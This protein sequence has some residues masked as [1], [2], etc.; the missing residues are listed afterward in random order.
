[1]IPK[2]RLAVYGLIILLFA[3]TACDVRAQGFGGYG[4]AGAY[5]SGS[6]K[7][8]ESTH[9]WSSGVNDAALDPESALSVITISGT[10][11][12]RVAP[13]QIRVVLAFTSEGETAEDCRKSLSAQ[14]GSVIADWKSLMIPDE[15]IVEDFISVLPRY[16]WRLNEELEGWSAARQ[17]KLVGYR[18]Q[19]NLHVAVKTEADAMAA[20][21]RAFKYGHAEIV[22]FDYWSSDL[23]QQQESVRASAVAAAKKKADTL[24]AVFDERPRVINVQESTAIYFPHSL[25]KTYENKLEEELVDYGTNRPP[26][27]KAYRPKMTFLHGLASRA[28]TRPKELLMRPEIAIVSTVRIYYRS[29][30]EGQAVS[31]PASW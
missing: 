8:F 23:D 2:I 18:M 14:V 3:S 22:T 5:S 13:E 4:G 9:I 1:M 16:E 24:L 15:N 30:A 17:Q 28:D 26:L 21:D 20:I 25:Y 6:G 11:E 10:A 27:I 31:K 19:I 12:H 7:E 29:P